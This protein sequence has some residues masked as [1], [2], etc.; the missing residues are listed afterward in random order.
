[1]KLP[2]PCISLSVSFL[3]ELTNLIKLVGRCKLVLLLA[4]RPYDFLPS[5]SAAI[6]SLSL[7]LMPPSRLPSPRKT[8]SRQCEN[9]AEQRDEIPRSFPLP[10]FLRA[11]LKNQDPSSDVP[12]T[13]SLSSSVAVYLPTEM[14]RTRGSIMPTFRET[15]G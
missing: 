14:S 3:R 15:A 11:T 4:S 1:M 9:V 2:S 8:R 7:S 13:F 12:R 5:F 6:H 10:V